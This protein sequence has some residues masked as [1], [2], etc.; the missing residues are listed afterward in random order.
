MGS[1]TRGVQCLDAG[2]S[3]QKESVLVWSALEC[4]TW[5]ETLSTNLWSMLRETGEVCSQRR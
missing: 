4:R 5:P 1:P 3:V 2:S